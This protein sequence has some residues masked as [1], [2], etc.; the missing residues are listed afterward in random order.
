M[1]GPARVDVL[2]IFLNEDVITQLISTILWRRNYW[3]GRVTWGGTIV[4]QSRSQT[5]SPPAMTV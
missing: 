2:D 4:P 5:V 1:T 3:K